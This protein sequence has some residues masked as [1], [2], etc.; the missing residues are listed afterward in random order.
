MHK[1]QQSLKPLLK[2]AD[3]I[4]EVRDARAPLASASKNP[5]YK[6]KQQHWVLLNKTN[7]A[8]PKVTK[9]WSAY[10]EQNNQAYWRLNVKQSPAAQ[11]FLQHLQNQAQIKWKSLQKHKIKPPALRVIIVGVPNTGKTSLI[12]QWLGTA[13]LKVGANPGIT[14]SLCWVSLNH[15]LE[16]L[17]TPGIMPPKIDDEQQL[18]WLSCLHAMP[19]QHANPVQTAMFLCGFLK[20][21]YPSLLE[22]KYQIQTC[23]N[24]IDTLN[25]IAEKLH[26]KMAKN[27]ADIN[28]AATKLLKDF[29]NGHLGKISL[30]HPETCS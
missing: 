20:Q 24:A 23:Q 10:F 27:Q 3:I 14:K 21:Q 25:L 1:A 2:H 12:N 7:L 17:D 15:E 5:S 9:R 30:E 18:Y 6:N 4:L 29:R 8:D 16:L 11:Q 13:S 19:E 26:Y 28:R 22:Q